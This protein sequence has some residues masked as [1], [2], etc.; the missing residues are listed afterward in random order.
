VALAVVFGLAG[1][2]VFVLALLFGPLARQD[3]PAAPPAPANREAVAAPAPAPR[4]A[5]AAP[6][7]S[8]KR[9]AEP[10]APATATV[11][12]GPPPSRAKPLA[13]VKLPEPVDGL[14]SYAGDPQTVRDLVFTPGTGPPGRA[15]PQLCWNVDATGFYFL[16]AGGTLRLISFPSLRE[17][18]LIILGQAAGRLAVGERGLLVTLPALQELWVLNPSSLAVTHR[19]GVAEVR[20]VLGAPPLKEALAFCA[21]GG[22][23]VVEFTGD[24]GR[25]SE[26][27]VERQEPSSLP[28]GVGGFGQPA[29]APD[30]RY[31]FALGT[32][33]QLL[34]YRVEGKSLFLED[35]SPRLA[36]P[37]SAKRPLCL[38]P[39]GQ[40]VCAP[41]PAGNLKAGDTLVFKA[42]NLS[43]PAFTLASGPFPQAVGFD[44]AAGLAYAQNAT[45]PLLVFDLMG[46]KKGE[47]NPGTG[48]A[49]P[50]VQ[51]ILVHPAGRRL[52]LLTD[53]KLYA[54]TPADEK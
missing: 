49:A 50:A 22:P 3:P 29:L 48:A 45:S 10:P 39:D 42:A 46:T 35:A 34:R 43:G 41:C 19:V 54:V 40:W 33:D 51:Q 9:G 8:P 52:V 5:A 13:D 47:Y 37:G 15:A 14:N 30:G 20:E 17:E 12:A 2:G 32:G 28:P 31:L 36:A 6:A 11:P 7:P 18:K 4:I 44:P 26:A 16:D 25:L 1:L 21:T 53:T 38:S 24:G 23:V 27:L